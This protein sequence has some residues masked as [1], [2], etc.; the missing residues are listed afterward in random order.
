MVTNRII[1]FGVP[2]AGRGRISACD[3][4]PSSGQ[5]TT[6]SSW[7]GFPALPALITS[8]TVIWAMPCSG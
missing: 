4:S 8:P 5:C 1:R 6:A 2:P 7:P 3:G